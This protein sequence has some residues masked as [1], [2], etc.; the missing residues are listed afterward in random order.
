MHN[1]MVLGSLSCPENFVQEFSHKI[2][3][4]KENFGIPKHWEL[5][6]VKISKSRE[7]FYISLIK[8]FCDTGYVRFRSLVADKTS[9]NHRMFNQSHDDWYYKMYY[10]LL[11]Y[12]L[13]NN[14]FVYNIYT[15]IKGSDCGKRNKKLMEVLGNKLKDDRVKRIQSIRSNE[16]QLLQ[17]SDILMG[18]TRY[19][20][21]V[22]KL[23]E[24]N[25]GFKPNQTKM[26]VC[27][28]L[29]EHFGE[30]IFSKTSSGYSQKF[31][32]FVW[33]AQ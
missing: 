9:L 26:K 18:A 15:D 24:S 25:P 29:K 5:K 20:K 22:G 27:N 21:R 8:L 6:W 14:G 4:L 28:M 17:L 33:E 11:I 23:L 30:S 12:I 31:N 2:K 3:A 7:D 13:R 1:D 19:E 10:T 32:V 16:S